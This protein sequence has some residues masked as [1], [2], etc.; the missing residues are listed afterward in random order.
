MNFAWKRAL[1]A[2]TLLVA[3]ACLGAPGQ[4]QQRCVA[5]PPPALTPPPGADIFTPQQEVDLGDVEAEQIE[6]NIRVIHDE[7]LAGYLNHVAERL[8]AQMPPTQ[9]RFRVILVDLPIVNS[10]SLSGG[11]IYVTRKMVAFLRNDDEIAGLLGHEMGHAL[12]HQEALRMTRVFREVL[13]VTSV[14]DRKD[15]FEKF[16]RLLDNVARNP[17]AVEREGNREE[18]EQGQADQV[19]LYAAANAGYSPQGFSAFFDR[20]A[21]TSGK[22]GNWLSDFFQTTRPDEKRLREIRKSLESLPPPCRPTTPASASPDF[23]EW[24]ASVIGYSGLGRIESL[25]GVVDKKLLDPPLR[26]DIT[27]LKFSPDGKYVLA[28]DDASVFVLSREPFHLLFRID[29]PDSH[30]A[31]FSPDSQNV[32]FDTRGMHVEKWSIAD[33]KRVDVHELAIPG[34]CVQTRLSPDGKSLAC[35]NRNF[36]ISLFDAAQGNMIFTKKGFFAPNI[37]GPFE[38][39]LRA[40]ALMLESEFGIEWAKMAFSPDSRTF[41]AADGNASLAV[42]MTTHNPFPLHG[43]LSGM[44]SGGFA[45]L[46]PDRVIAVNRPDPKNSAIFKF[47]SGELVEKLL[48]GGNLRAPT[49]G[50][51]VIAGPLKDFTVGAL[52]LSSHKFSIGVRDSAAL[53]VYDNLAVLQKPSGE[54]ELVELGFLKIQAVANIPQSPLGVLRAADASP[55]LKWVA[56]SGATRA[57]I[58]NVSTGKRLYFTRGFRGAFFDGDTAFFADFPKLEP[59]ER[60]IA[61]MALD[62]S[63]I[64]PAI[65]VDDQSAVWQWGHYLLTRK[66]A[67]KHG[68]LFANTSLEVKSVRD[69]Q[70]L[71]TRTFPKELPSWTLDSKAGTLLVGWSI[72]EDA[73]KEEIKQHPALQTRLA[74]MRDR[75]GAWVL[76]DLD[77]A[78]GKQ[79]GELVV[80]TGKGSFRIQNWYAAGDWVIV[81][82]NE[83]RTLVYS[84]STGEQKGTVFGAR[85]IVSIPAGL[86]VVENETGRLD[87]YSLPSLEKRGQLI[88]SSPISLEAFSQDGQRLFVLTGNQTAYTFDASAVAHG[89]ATTH[90]TQMS[91]GAK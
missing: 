64:K 37:S 42:D 88:F 86:L 18:P 53:D 10:F 81:T 65:P 40:Y 38:Q 56:L 5:P 39:L 45:F 77:A 34:G 35:M 13:G 78:T 62:G 36:D 47:P 91:A 84:L 20:L 14:G 6:R 17:K 67:G 69:G 58:W 8:L 51:Y 22:T 73:A 11:R 82:D 46:S 49:H 68:S 57:A 12:T 63:G 76:E 85:S 31:Q 90:T 41:L 89:L 44:V 21:Q 24:Q 1:L 55:D 70:V 83:N 32:V 19:A 48:L 28:Q 87:I 16:N 79:I 27:H 50:N 60:S 25:A 52:D 4:A 74:A 3:A 30:P 23:L 7:Q 71:W 26:N 9:L 66:P 33:E 29:A 2:P 75:T 80:D 54:L 61:R 43:A 59:Q 15:I 72:N